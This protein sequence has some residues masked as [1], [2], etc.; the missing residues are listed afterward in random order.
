[1]NLMPHCHPEFCPSNNSRAKLQTA[2]SRE[3]TVNDLAF[4]SVSVKTICS[5]WIN[6][7]LRQGGYVFFTVCH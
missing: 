7:Y 3:M 6:N 1:M 2:Q 5:F 4:I